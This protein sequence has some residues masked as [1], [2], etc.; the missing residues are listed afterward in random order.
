MLYGWLCWY[1]VFFVCRQARDAGIM[2]V[3]VVAVPAVVNDRNE[4]VQTVQKNFRMCR[5]CSSC[6]C[7]RRCEHAATSPGVSGRWVQTSS[8]TK[9]WIASVGFSGVLRHFSHPSAWKRV[10]IFQPLSTHTVSAR[11]RQELDCQLDRTVV[12]T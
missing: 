5:K 4:W 1:A 8:S 7:G 11:S 9:S 3:V 12:T 6:G 2:V 10:P